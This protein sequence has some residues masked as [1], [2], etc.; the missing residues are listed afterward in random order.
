MSVTTKW[1]WS[2]F[3]IWESRFWFCSDLHCVQK[4]Q[5]IH[6]WGRNLLLRCFKGGSGHTQMVGKGAV[7]LWELQWQQQPPPGAPPA[8]GAAIRA[9]QCQHSQH[10]ISPGHRRTW[11]EHSLAT[12]GPFYSFLHWATSWPPPWTNR[13]SQAQATPRDVPEP[14]GCPS[15][16]QLMGFWLGLWVPSWFLTAWPHTAILTLTHSSW[17]EAFCAQFA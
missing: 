4:E 13:L 5:Q 14:Q 15:V 12:L 17:W 2:K 6:F 9:A 3:I 8:L 11:P 10:R 7:E 1:V 16:P